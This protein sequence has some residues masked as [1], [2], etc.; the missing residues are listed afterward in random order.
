MVLTY[1]LIGGSYMEKLKPVKTWVDRITTILVVASLA[2]TA[3]VLLEVV[4]LPEVIV[5]ALAYGFFIYIV[6]YLF[7]KLK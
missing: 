4:E 3:I 1:K 2:L 6:V 5:R 7:Q